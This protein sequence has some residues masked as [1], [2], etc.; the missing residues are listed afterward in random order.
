MRPFRALCAAAFGVAATLAAAQQWPARPILTVGPYSAGA[1]TDVVGRIVLDQVGREIGQPFVIETRPGAGGVVGV[2]SVVRAEPDGYTTLLSS[3]SMSSAVIT[4]A[5]LPYDAVRDLRG[6]AMFGVQPNV[7]VVSPGKGYKNVADL[8][9]AAKAKP[10]ALNF[11]SAGIGSASHISG[12]RFALAAGIAV[13][14]IPFK[15][16]EALNELMAGRL[17][18]Y[19]V[20]L[21]PAVG[22][23][24]Q[25]KVLPLAVST[26]ERAPLLPDV[27]S[28]A[29]AGY[30]DAEYLFWGGLSAPAKTPPDIIDKLNA[31]VNKSLDDAQ[32]REKL[33][34]IGVMPLPM[35]PAQYQ[36]YFA[37]DVA[38]MEKLAKDAHIEPTE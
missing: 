24:S 6:V 30:P 20:P 22:L 29:E 12:T 21:A 9:A 4:H 27:P 7:L 11:G 34:K 14:H 37:D 35:T 13:Q 2:G 16:P 33:F 3:S 15:G 18:Y 32:V 28:I 5:S 10:G 19:F 31:A 23:I 38:A 17:D 25:G 26:R 36:K 8:V 1:A